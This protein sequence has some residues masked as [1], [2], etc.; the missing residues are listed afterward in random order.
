MAAERLLFVILPLVL[1]APLAASSGPEQ[2]DQ[3]AAN[4]LLESRL[5]DLQQR[6]RGGELVPLGELALGAPT[7]EE[8][9]EQ[10]DL[11]T[12]LRL[13]IEPKVARDRLLP[14]FAAELETLSEM[15]DRMEAGLPKESSPL[16]TMLLDFETEL[17]TIADRRRQALGLVDPLRVAN[18][19]GRNEGGAA[20]PAAVDGVDVTD[21]AK[22]DPTAAARRA[23][24]DPAI[25]AAALYRAAR[26][27]EA[28]DAFARMPPGAARTP[29]QEHQRADA[30]MRIGQV[31]EAIAIW[32]KLAVDHKE[33][34]W[35][36]Q[37]SFSL[38]V[39]RAL[40]ALQ[41]AKKPAAAG[42]QP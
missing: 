2:G 4:R 28:L 22:A 18:V 21:A 24:V 29:E 15:R 6:I 10:L 16:L 31:D 39:A 23:A 19:G 34:S 26:W 40:S 37:A 33:S 14:G 25:A 3:E 20:A 42:G 1:C 41:K 11:R 12:A 30:L 38:K 5:Q 9:L 32:E 27:Q 17:R 7:R 36:Q 35:G 13:G 8:L